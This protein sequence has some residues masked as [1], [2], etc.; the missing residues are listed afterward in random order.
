MLDISKESVGSVIE[1]IK[2]ELQDLSLTGTKKIVQSSMELGSSAVATV[3]EKV[4]QAAE[5]MGNAASNVGAGGKKVVNAVQETVQDC[6]EGLFLV[7]DEAATVIGKGASE[8]FDKAKETVT[9]FGAEAAQSMQKVREKVKET[10]GQ[11]ADFAKESLSQANTQAKK[12]ASGIKGTAHDAL[13]GLG[14]VAHETGKVFDKGVKEV[15]DRTQNVLDKGRRSVD[16]VL[17]K[18]RGLFRRNKD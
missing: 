7:A 5:C 18:V 6:G 15:K 9:N 8:G 4:G 13:D 3:K 16:T 1:A 12:V 14:M 2:K 11:A 17:G 10:A